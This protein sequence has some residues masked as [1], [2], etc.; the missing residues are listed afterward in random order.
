MN[1]KSKKV[2]LVG[3][4]IL[5]GGVSMAKWLLKQDV[6]LTITDLKERK[7]L[8]QSLDKLKGYPIKYVLGAHIEDDFKTSD[9]IVLNPDVSLKNKFIQIATDNNIPLENELTLFSKYT[10]NENTIF[11]TGTRGKTTT[12]NWTAYLLNAD[13]A[14]NSPQNLLMDALSIKNKPLVVETPSFVLELFGLKKDIPNI[15]H[16]ALI[17][18]IYTDHL[19]RH[20]TLKNYAKTKSYIFKNQN[21][22]DYLILNYNNEWTDFFLRQ[23]PKSKILFFSTKRLPISKEGVYIEKGT[24]K[25]RLNKKTTTISPINK[26]IEEWGIN[27]LPN[28]LGAVLIAYIHNVSIKQIKNKLAKLPT[29]KFRQ[30]RIFKKNKLCVYNDTTATSPEATISAINRFKGERIILITGGTD[31]MLKFKEL[32][33]VI[34]SN[35]KT[36]DIILLSGSATNKMKKFLDKKT[37]EFNTLF[38]C[39][40]EAKRIIDPKEKTV[41]LFS[42]AS[43]SF[44]KFKNEFDRGE[45][46]NK[47]VDKI[48]KL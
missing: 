22:E 46:F 18:N 33:K 23:K 5:G 32:T 1:L 26:F 9:L 17:T 41:I 6:K 10:R 25:I 4:G 43:K 40:Y 16:I 13:I 45:Q 47:L 15:P 29:I 27:N 24:I 39:I 34:R 37:K 12:V 30:Q 38:D 11:I 44:E 2:L 48:F 7:I 31:R 35:V 21:K 36:E 19:N 42:P 3:L 8:Q 28:L 14:G 20:G